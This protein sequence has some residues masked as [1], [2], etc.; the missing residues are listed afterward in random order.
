MDAYGAF[1]L[2]GAVAPRLPARLGFALAG[3]AADA[4][5]PFAA[6]AVS[7]LR[8]NI[9]RVLGPA[10]P[11]GRVE[12]VVRQAYRTLLR[13]YYGMFYLSGQ[14]VEQLRAMIE[15]VNG[16]ELQR[17]VDLGRGVILC[18]AHLG[19]PEAGM[20]CAAAVGF[21]VVGPAEHVQPDKLFRYLTDLRTRHGLRLIPT[22]GP[23]LDLFR[24]LRR[25]DIVGITVDRDT[26]GSGVPVEMCGAPA[27]LPDGYAR[28]VAKTRAP[29]LAGF[30]YRLAAGRWRIEFGPS[31]V[32]AP[33]AAQEEVYR[34]ALE[35]GVRALE[36]AATAHPD[37]WVLTTPVWLD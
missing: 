37:Q 11:P 13:N 15:I 9:A 1:R 20:Q 32:P 19:D 22:D 2:A 14:S 6:G 18:T 12:A 24:A 26:T 8:S 28:L 33:V 35:L 25:G 27:H 3:W 31:F 29:L 23:M 16:D 17:L 34:H 10:T 30:C 36:S 4:A 5:Y 7:G 21:K